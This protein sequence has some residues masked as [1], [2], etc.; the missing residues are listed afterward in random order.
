MFRGPIELPE[1]IQTQCIALLNLGALLR[2]YSITTYVRVTDV[3]RKLVR[4]KLTV[5][6][7]QDIMHLCDVVSQSEGVNE[8]LRQDIRVLDSTLAVFIAAASLPVRSCG[9][10][11]H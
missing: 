6:D 2:L 5:C 10:E 8:S 11:H 3:E 9:M 1:V 4:N 7:L